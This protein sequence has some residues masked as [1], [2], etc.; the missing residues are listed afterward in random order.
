[1]KL[2]RVLLFI[3]ILSLFIPNPV[4]AVTQTRAINA[5]GSLLSGVYI[6]GATDYTNLN[7]DDGDASVLRMSMHDSH[8]YDM[9]NFVSAYSSINSVSLT[10]KVRK[11]ADFLVTYTPFV[12]IA[13]INYNG[14]SW[15]LPFFG[16]AYQSHTETWNTNPATGVAWTSTQINAAE[17]GLYVTTA[18]TTQ[19]TYL[20]ITVDYVGVAL[21]SV[22]TSA[23]S[24]ISYNGTHNATLNG[25]ITNTG[26]E[27]ADYRGFC[28]GTTS[29]STTPS[30][31]EVPPA[32]YT[33]NQTFVG[34]FSTG[35]FSHTVTGL[36]LHTTYYYRAY[37]HNSIGWSYGTERS[38]TTLNNPSVNTV[39]ASIIAVS[40]ARL[41]ALVVNDGGEVCTI[42][43]AYAPTAGGPYANYA[44]IVAAGNV[45]NTTGTWSTGQSPFVNISGLTGVTSYTFM[46]RITNSVS[47][48]YGSQLTFTTQSGIIEP[49]G[50]KGIPDA[51]YISLQWV[52][53]VG[54][55]NTLIRYKTGSYPIDVAD[56]TQVYF[57]TQT[58]TVHNS[59]TPGTTYYYKAWGESGG[60]YSSGNITL[61]VT[62]LA[63]AASVNI[64][65][66]PQTPTRWYQSPNYMRMSNLPFYG[67][68]NWWADSFGIP[69]PTIWSTLGLLF[70]MMCGIFVY[71]KSQKTLLADF[72][73]TFL[74]LI[75][76]FMELIT[77]WV[78]LPF[79]L[80]SVALIV[81]GER[82]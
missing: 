54:S 56:G 22:S 52:K 82:L 71:A 28:W 38:F 7:S 72:V 31:G 1:M 32:S 36:L 14:A 23:A 58:S 67:I 37:S 42:Q 33:S 27:N 8:S 81:V 2:L 16:G 73:V 49:T 69:R 63:S 20:Y 25:E 41:N 76:A 19:A 35:T 43:F 70:S 53:G 4:Y 34:S 51:T 21:G 44:A 29:N 47:S 40:T 11:F 64:L 60:S 57:S 75:E 45:A 9:Q 61:L 17:F 65:P 18:T 24:G 15:D 68:V 80:L 26:G 62:T 66:P 6:G 48:Q 13:G 10:F 30:S 77:M 50:F 39:A 46:V 3:I 74:M 78:V 12:R 59:L 55:T 79:A 5:E